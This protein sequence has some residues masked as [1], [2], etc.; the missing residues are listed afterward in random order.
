MHATTKRGTISFFHPRAVWP[1]SI[2]TNTTRGD[3][4]TSHV[5][6]RG[7]Q[8]AYA[9]KLR[10]KGTKPTAAFAWSGAPGARSPTE[11]RQH[12][13]ERVD[14]SLLHLP[15]RP[16]MRLAAFAL[17]V[18]AITT[19]VV[20]KVGRTRRRIEALS[21]RRLG[22]LRALVDG[23]QSQLRWLVRPPLAHRR[24]AKLRVVGIGVHLAGQLV[25]LPRR[26]SDDCRV[27]RSCSRQ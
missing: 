15:R 4:A 24:A 6:S 17:L 2:G 14:L 8:P 25:Q 13:R 11:G 12:L 1:A 20:I 3:D 18:A 7:D 10:R 21:K 19:T 27:I 23:V 9:N 26:A 5:E 16:I 22:M